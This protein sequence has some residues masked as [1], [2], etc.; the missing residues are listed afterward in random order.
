[1]NKHTFGSSA[2]HLLLAGLLVII[3]I[4]PVLWIIITSIKPDNEMFSIPV[5]FFPKKINFSNYLDVLQMDRFHRYFLNSIV[6]TVGA[7]FINI[8][9]SLITGY[10]FSRF[11]FKGAKVLLTLII[12]TQLFPAAVL[13]IPLYKMWAELRLLNTYPSLILTYAVFTL[14]LSIW[15]LTGFMNTIPEEIDQSALV[16]GCSKWQSLFRII[17]P[18]S[19]PGIM[20]SAI[21]V[22]IVVWQEFLFALTFINSDLMRTLPIG[23]YSFIG[24]RVTDWGPLM[25][26]SVFTT[27]PIIVFFMVSQTQFTHGVA[28]AVKA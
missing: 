27:I 6:V 28:G 15:M 18:L 24:E 16:D 10:S 2:I 11:K 21:Y 4:F 22:F 8:F 13:L 7:T 9:F 26:A 17:L 3:I 23:L 14:P 20:A 19:K 12:L 1:M 5:T 25:A